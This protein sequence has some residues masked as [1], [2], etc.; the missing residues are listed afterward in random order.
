MVSYIKA[1]VVNN[2]H[3]NGRL[4]SLQV[5]ADV[6]PFKA[7]QFTKLAF[8]INDECIGR[9]YSYIN[10]PGEYPLEFYANTVPE[11][12]ISQHLYDLEPGARIWI[13]SKPY[14]FLTLEGLP[15]ADILW[16]LST[17]TAIGPFLSILKTGEAW[18]RF[19]QVVLIHAVRTHDELTYQETIAE[20]LDRYKMRFTYIPFISRET[21]GYAIH[22]RVPAAIEDGRLEAEAGL[23]IDVTTSQVMIC[24]NPPMVNDTLAVLKARGLTLNRKKAPGQI[25]L[26]RYL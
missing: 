25:T 20:F 26:E 7:G 21:E 18:S 23:P 14:G 4:F 15:A 16:M 1:E 2:H 12:A 17:G 13:S 9:P 8:D 24:G 19:G 3:W 22:G 5:E 10:A 6:K 11:G